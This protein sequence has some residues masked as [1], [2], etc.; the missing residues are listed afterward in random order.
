MQ[1]Y[2][3]L[4]LV[5]SSRKYGFTNPFQCNTISKPHS[6]EQGERYFYE[7]YGVVRYLDK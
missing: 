5:A 4:S 6:R 7:L 3:S 2:K 1:L